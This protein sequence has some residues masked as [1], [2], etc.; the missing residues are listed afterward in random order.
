MLSNR[1]GSNLRI[2]YPC[3][4]IIPANS[5]AKELITIR[6]TNLGFFCALDSSRVM[7]SNRPEIP[8]DINGKE[9]AQNTVPMLSSSQ[10]KPLVLQM[11]IKDK[12][13]RKTKTARP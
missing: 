8:I 11:E 6:T 12:H 1:A 7:A 2:R 3:P 9:Y 10:T 5:A 4:P 13:G